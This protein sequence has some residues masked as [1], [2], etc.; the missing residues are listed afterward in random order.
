MITPSS[1]TDKQIYLNYFRIHLDMKSIKEED[2]IRVVDKLRIK[3]DEGII[4]ATMHSI[5][6]DL[7]LTENETIEFLEALKI[8]SNKICFKI[9]LT[10]PNNDQG[11]KIISNLIK[12]YLPSIRNC[13]YVESLGG[14]SYHSLMSLSKNKIII[15]CGNSSSIIK[16]APFFGAHS[17]NIGSRQLGRESSNTQ[18]DSKAERNQIVN[19]LIKLAGEKCNKGYNPYFKDNSSEHILRFIKRTFKNRSKEEILF[20]RWNRQI[21]R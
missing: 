21:N 6:K 14:K 1:I 11:N 5:P 19:N 18:L 20:K 17:L 7:K 10:S 16:E 15:V 2:R 8:V 9:I 13:K 3:D 12:T 4:L